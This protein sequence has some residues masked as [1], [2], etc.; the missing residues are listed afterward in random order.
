M[1]LISLK[2]FFALAV[3]STSAQATLLL[4]DF[5]N[6]SDL[7][8]YG[9]SGPLVYQ[10]LGAV[11]GSGVEL[12]ISHFLSNPTPWWAGSVTANLDPLTSLLILT[13]Q[14]INPFQTF[15]ATLNNIIFS[16]PGEVI[17]GVSLVS[18]NLTN[19]G[20]TPSISFTENSLLISYAVPNVAAGDLFFF[21]GS[22]AIFQIT[23]GISAIPEPG[24]MLA[25]AGLL[26][27]GTLLRNRRSL[28]KET[29]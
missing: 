16:N 9:G 15:T 20:I 21:T 13:S 1:K 19:T 26:G 5:R 28:A 29:V 4:A 14:S 18:G 12:D 23:T 24:S 2:F 27:A 17:T 22:D 11:I 8:R 25:I 7:P 10:N 6:E 3:F